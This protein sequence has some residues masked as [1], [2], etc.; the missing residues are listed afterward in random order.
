M[1]LFLHK[2][3]FRHIKFKHHHHTPPLS[4]FPAHAAFLFLII[5][6]SYYHNF[7]SHILCIFITLIIHVQIPI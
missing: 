6:L 3:T 5:P 7:A 4:R 2:N 1:E